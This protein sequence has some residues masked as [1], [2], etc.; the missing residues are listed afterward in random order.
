M[1]PKRAKSEWKFGTLAYQ[2]GDL[3]FQEGD[4]G[5][6]AYIVQS[7]EI[8]IHKSRGPG[9]QDILLGT[10]TSGAVFGEMALV[11]NAPRMASAI[12]SKSAILKVIPVDVFEAKLSDVD[13]FIRALI[14]VLVQNVRANAAKVREVA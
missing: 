4:L 12:C 10:L 1:D 6:E 13:P 8:E 7:G 11:D 14:R 9:K 2:A 3:V 5:A